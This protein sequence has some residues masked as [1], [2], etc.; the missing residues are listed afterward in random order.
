MGNLTMETFEANSKYIKPILKTKSS[1]WCVDRLLFSRFSLCVS[2]ICDKRVN[3]KCESAPQEDTWAFQLYG[4]PF[5]EMPVKCFGQQNQYVALCFPYSK[6]ELT[7]TRDLKG[8]IQVLQYKGDHLSLGYWCSLG[9][10]ILRLKQ[11]CFSRQNHYE[12]HGNALDDMLII[13]RELKGGLRPAN[14]SNVVPPVAPAAPP[15]NLIMTHN[16][17]TSELVIRFLLL[18]QFVLL[19]S[20]EPVMGRIWNDKGKIAA[21]FSLGG[22]EYRNSIGSIQVLLDLPERV[23]GYDYDWRSFK[24]AA[25][26]SANKEWHP[27]HVNHHKGDISPGVLLIDG[28]EMLGRADLASVLSSLLSSLESKTRSMPWR[29]PAPQSCYGDEPSDEEEKVFSNLQRLY[30]QCQTVCLLLF[31]PVLIKSIPYCTDGAGSKPRRSRSGSGF[32]SSRQSSD[33]ALKL[34]TLLKQK[35]HLK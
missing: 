15:A 14:V 22:H 31:L 19:A 13:V 3:K 28:K 27:V 20:G 1:F 25:D 35:V 12:G 7:G 17:P 29:S 21:C 16:W 18:K 10:W 5:P 33:N 32:D 4:T 24:E 9:Y 8:E 2:I 30:L 6:A 11:L 23:R 26:F 34:Q